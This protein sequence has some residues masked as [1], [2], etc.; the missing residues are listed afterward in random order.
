MIKEI[1][2][3]LIKI[4]DSTGVVIFFVLVIATYHRIAEEGCLTNSLCL[5]TLHRNLVPNIILYGPPI[6]YN[7]Y[8]R[9][10]N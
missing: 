3:K 9:S 2:D 6:A 5:T 1:N 4:F 7:Y 10:Y 8:C